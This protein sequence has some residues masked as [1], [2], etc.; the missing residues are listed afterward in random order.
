MDYK[1]RAL[2]QLECVRAKAKEKGYTDQY[3]AEKMGMSRPNVTRML[4]GKHLPRLDTFMLLCD[5]VGVPLI[6]VCKKKKK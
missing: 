4:S 6:D 1:E 2:A 3:I 5:T